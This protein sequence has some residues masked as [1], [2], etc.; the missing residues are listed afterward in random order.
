MEGLSPKETAL[1]EKI[2]AAPF[3]ELSTLNSSE[4]GCVGK[5]SQ[6]G[7]VETYKDYVN[8]KKCV[9]IKQVEEPEEVTKEVVE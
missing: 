9:R 7:L 8:R 4:I 6:K 3:I 1:Y 2:L 5:L